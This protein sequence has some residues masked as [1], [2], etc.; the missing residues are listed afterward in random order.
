MAEMADELVA[1]ARRLDVDADVLAIWSDQLQAI[2]RTGLYYTE[3]D[4]DRERYEQILSIAADIASR[5]TGVATRELV[6]RWAQD[7]GYVTPKVGVVGVVFNADQALLLLQ[8]SDTG[9]WCPPVGWAD[10]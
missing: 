2:A 7:I 1:S 8:R 10:V 9:L 6:G 4:Y 3:S 5:R